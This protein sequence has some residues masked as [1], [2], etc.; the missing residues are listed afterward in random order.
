MQEISLNAVKEAKGRPRVSY[1][2][3]CEVDEIR[4]E[5]RNKLNLKRTPSFALTTQLIA[6]NY[7]MQSI[8]EDILNELTIEKIE[9]L[10]KI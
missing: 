5:L 10:K 7:K 8:K 6:R 2:F 1:A 4:F 3:A 9:E